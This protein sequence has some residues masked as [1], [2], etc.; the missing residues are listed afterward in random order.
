ML[1]YPSCL[2]VVI[3]LEDPP[4]HQYIIDYQQGQLLYQLVQAIDVT[5]TGGSG[6]FGII[7]ELATP[8]V[9]GVQTYQLWL[10]TKQRNI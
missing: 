6:H 3:N 8:I 2:D 10:S 9:G 7:K 5:S 1:T 4:L